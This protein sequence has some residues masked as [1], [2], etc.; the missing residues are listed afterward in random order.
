M[1]SPL[2]EKTVLSKIIVPE[3]SYSS[4]K[5]L[6]NCE[7]Q[8]F[9]EKVAKTPV[10]S[11]YEDSDAFGVGKAFHKV[12]EDTLHNKYDKDLLLKAM[13][14]EK[15]DAEDY[16]MLAGML[17]KYVRV[18]KLSG[19]KVIK[20]ELQVTISKR[21]NG[22]I[23]M[24]MVNESSGEWWLGDLKTTKMLDK[25]LIPRLPKDPQ[26]NLYSY[27]YKD[28]ASAYDL[29]PDLFQGCRYRAV[30]KPTIKMKS[31]ETVDQYID[32]LEEHC[33]AYDIE[34]PFSMMDIKGVWS[35]HGEAHDRASQ[36][37]AGEAPK[38]N[39]N[40]CISY[41]KPCKFFSQCHGFEFSKGNDKVKVHTLTSFT[42]AE[43][44]L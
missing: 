40:G 32:R 8:Y 31:K 19:L 5:V 11:D 21:F 23:D 34:V 12:M 25:T 17:K 9:H 36:L 7:Q 30:T 16:P 38:R 43:D 33:E 29:D 39:Y 28:I 26:L 37:F 27:F 24:I 41:F 6:Y 1:K 4:M 15:V 42:E 2:V 22:F 35:M 20:C 3:L 44:S 10:D 18:H 13:E 14:D